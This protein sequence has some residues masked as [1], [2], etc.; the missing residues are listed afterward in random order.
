MK[1]IV[2]GTAGHI[3]HGKTT[4]IKALTGIDCD[5]LK[6]EKERGITTELGFAHYRF[7]D[8]LLLGIVDVPGHEKFVRHMVA[9]AWG[10]DMVLLVVAADEGVM[11]QTREHL[12]ICEILG[13]RKGIVAITKMDLVDKEMVEL[14]M[15]DVKDTL[16]GRSLE[17][18]E[19]IPV[20]ATTGEN[21]DLLKNRITAA[22]EEV[23]ERPRLGIFRL[24]VD[25]VFTLKGLGVVVTGTCISGAIKVGEEVEIFPLHKRARVRNIQAYHQDVGEAGA[26][27]RVALNLQGVERQEL[28]RGTV[29][30]RPQ[31]LMLS[32][33]MDATLKYLKL[34]LKPIKNNTIMRFHVATTHVEARVILLEKDSVEPGEEVFVQFVLAHPIVVLPAD[35]FILR[36][37]YA[38]Q[39]VGGGAVLDIEPERHRRKS[40][41][42]RETYR[43]LLNGSLPERAEY[44]V[45]KGSYGGVRIDRLPLLLGSNDSAVSR[46]IATLAG[47]GKVT[48]VGKTVV[49]S[50]LFRDYC[51]MLLTHTN[52]FHAR[53]P[54]KIGMSKEELRT[55]LPKVETQVFHAALD[56]CTSSGGIDVDKDKVRA[57]ETGKPVDAGIEALGKKIVKKL[58]ISGLTPPSVKEMAE[59]LG[60]KEGY[61]KDILARLSREG[62]LVR[63]T[64]DLFFHRDAIEDLK[65]KAVAYLRERKEM[66]PAD[67]K[68]VVSVSR[69]YMIPLL[70]HLDEIKL[71]IRSGDK[72]ILR[73]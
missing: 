21:L 55:K 25:R 53:N 51:R 63:V 19:I 38:V 49:M 3:D 67:F 68:S 72:R 69:K 66:T 34:P 28:E 60:E 5:R 73:G 56:E 62:T 30:G 41:D 6:E 71:T 7:G 59:E 65:V 42:L 26:G 52:E 20:S 70:E 40:P 50:N 17:S 33:R 43:L 15:E 48:S 32:Q 1:Q 57:K 39:T 2:I 44:H 46:V 54:Q 12:D 23:Q 16:A 11:P 22:A 13:L 45:A 58:S 14:V 64:G 31:T 4:L 9:G 36:G 61:L 47:T 18:S 27:Q 24:P 35:R 8:D 10:M 29:I 37:S